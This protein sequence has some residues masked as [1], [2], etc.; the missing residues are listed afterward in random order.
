MIAPTFEFLYF[1]FFLFCFHLCTEKQRIFVSEG[2]MFLHGLR[3]DGCSRCPAVVTV[4]CCLP[5]PLLNMKDVAVS[6]PGAGAGGRNI[7]LSEKTE[8]E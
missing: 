1:A 8:K 4:Q 5:P 7:L 2:E 3:T 6:L